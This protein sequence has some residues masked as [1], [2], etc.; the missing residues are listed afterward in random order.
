MTVQHVFVLGAKGLG[1]YGGYET[2]IDKLTE[3]HQN[4]SEIKYHVACK[5]NGKGKMDESKLQGVNKIDDVNFVYHNADCFKIHV[6][7]VGPAQAIF[8]DLEALK[9]SIDYCRKHQIE[10]PIFY[11]L[12]CRIGPFIGH[13]IK[14]IHRLSG[15]QL[16]I[17]PDGHE[18][19]RAKWSKPV[20]KYWKESERLMV[21]HAD[22]LVCD[23]V[24]IEKYIRTTYS[25]YHPK[26]T[27]IAYGADIAASKLA[28]NDPK[29]LNWL[30]DHNLENNEYYLIVGRFVPENNFETMIREFMR[31][32]SSKKL[33]I[34]T[35][36]DDKFLTE[37]N[38][39]LHFESDPRIEF[40]GTVYDQ[41]LLKKIREN[42]Y[43]YLHGHS[44]GG[45]NPSLLEA[46]SSTQ[47]NLLL[48][49]GFNKEVGKDAAL[50]WNKK[51]GNLANLI[52]EADKLS[53]YKIESFDFESRKRIMSK[54]SWKKIS[55][56]Y[57]RLFLKE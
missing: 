6:P 10:H 19:K 37:L 45:T 43:G 20:R 32:H 28:D 52:D 4:I 56:E 44:V 27:Y 15:G 5:Q 35:T 57:K 34:I 29:Y 22:L 36:K 39:K 46:L 50:Y 40:V 9:Y 42:A 17:N 31:S 55:D 8:Y 30:K 24:N 23:S 51:P 21:K 13:Y 11:V 54:Y 48:D 3:Y 25:K 26:T 7:E 18:W 47:L 2:F 53:N 1:N 38:E 16:F 49:V 41:E 12:A 14:Q 33:A